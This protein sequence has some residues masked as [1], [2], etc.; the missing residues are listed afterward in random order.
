MGS[1]YKW[2]KINKWV[3]V[4]GLKFHPVFV[5]LFVHPT[6]TTTGDF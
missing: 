1:P 5:E 4:P 6:E 3:G 2:P